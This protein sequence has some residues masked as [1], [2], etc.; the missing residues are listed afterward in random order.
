MKYPFYGCTFFTCEQKP[1]T[2]VVAS[3]DG[4][5]PAAPKGGHHVGKVYLGISCTGIAV[6]SHPAKVCALYLFFLMMSVAVHL[7]VFRL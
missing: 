5:A 7:R 6:F 3:P 4:P 2:P 1:C